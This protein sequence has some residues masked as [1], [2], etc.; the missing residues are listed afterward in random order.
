MIKWGLDAIELDS[1]RM[2]GYPDLKPYRG[3]IM[4]WGC[5][6]IQSIY[7]TG[8]K[9]FESFIE[10]ND[11]TSNTKIV[12]YIDQKSV[13][14]QVDLMVTR[15][16]ATTAAEIMVIGVP[17][18]IIPSPFV[19]NNHQFYNAKALK[20]K[21]AIILVEEKELDSQK[22]FSTILTLLDDENKMHEMREN[23]KLL[24]HPNAA[25]DFINWIFEELNNG[26]IN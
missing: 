19:P 25:Q 21:K 14:Q 9:H 15:G 23:A 13:M 11:E 17:S 20:E 22:L 5:V 24:G 26:R 1:P 10:T 6:N 4:F 12:P 2:S 7:V 18:I 8:K 3:K 16:G